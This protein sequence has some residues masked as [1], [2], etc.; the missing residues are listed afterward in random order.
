MN[1]VSSYK[2]NQ[3]SMPIENTFIISKIERIK[4]SINKIKS[5]LQFSDGEILR[6][7]D[8]LAVL[9]RNFQLIVDYAIDINHHFIK[10]GGYGIPDDL[11]STFMTL[12][13]HNI[14]PKEF[15]DKIGR[16]VG[17]RNRIVHQYED[18][19][20]AVFVESLRKNIGDYDEYIKHILSNIK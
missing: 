17:L 9:E 20:P 19:K 14:L 3:N 8:H 2:F 1:T 13:E 15:A 10:E 7:D 18:V 4:E 5:K 11:Q 16:S 12:G 6:S